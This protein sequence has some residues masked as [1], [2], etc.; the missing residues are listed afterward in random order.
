MHSQASLCTQYLA[1]GDEVNRLIDSQLRCQTVIHVDVVTY[2]MCRFWSTFSLVIGTSWRGV[3]TKQVY[4]QSVILYSEDW[5]SYI[6]PSHHRS[7]RYSRCSWFTLNWWNLCLMSY[8]MATGS[9]RNRQ[10]TQM[11]ALVRSGP[12]IRQSSRARFLVELRVAVKHNTY[13]RRFLR[14]VM[15]YIAH[16]SITPRRCTVWYSLSVPVLDNIFH[17]CRVV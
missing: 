9:R 4:C 5:V 1:L 2:K 7:R 6:P 17:E 12:W 10:R 3:C 13:I 16:M 8:M 15:R 14:I 11:S